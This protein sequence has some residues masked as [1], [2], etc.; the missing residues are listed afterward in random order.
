MLLYKTDQ[1]SALTSTGIYACTNVQ[2]LVFV[3]YWMD[4]YMHISIYT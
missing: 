3:K 2:V 1:V 4:M